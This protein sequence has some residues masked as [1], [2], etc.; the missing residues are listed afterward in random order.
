V[1]GD[2]DLLDQLN[3]QKQLKYIY[4]LKSKKSKKYLQKAFV[5]LF[6]IKNKIESTNIMAID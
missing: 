4:H 5:Y 3:Y 6:M 2:L 1:R